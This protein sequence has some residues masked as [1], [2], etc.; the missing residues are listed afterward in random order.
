M[1]ARVLDMGTDVRTRL[2]RV[3]LGDEPAEAVLTG[4]RVV[5]VFTREIVR[6]DVV[7]A[8]G[9][10]AAVGDSGEQ[11]I[12]P[13]TE[14]ID[15]GGR[16]AAPGLID[17]HMHLESSNIT[18][19]ELARA[20]VPRG[21]LSVCEDPHEIANVL[22][23][24]GVDLLTAEAAR[25]PLN[26][27]LRVPGRVPAM[28]ADRETSGH[29]MDTAET[30]AMLDRPEAVC[31]GG[32]INPAL[33][34]GADRAQLEKI[35]ATVERDK[36]VGGQLPGFS[37]A[38]LDATLA[39]G[40]E[41]THVAE[42]PAEVVEQLRKGARVLLTPRIDRLPAEEWPEIVAATERLGLDTRRLVLC[43]DDIHPNILMSE[44][45]LDQRVRLAVEA[46][47]DPL[48]AVQMATLNA[49]ELM[50][51]DRHLGS[52]APGRFADLVL[53]ES[54]DE[55]APSTVL[56]RGEVVAADGTLVQTPPPADYPA[57]STGTLH[58]AVPSPADLALRVEAPDGPVTANAVAFGAPK[59]MHRVQLRARDGVVGPDSAADAA[60]IAVLER[61]HRTG[62]IGKGFVTGLGIRGGAV[63]STVNHDSHNVV[64]IGDSHA[65]MAAAAGAVI[66]AQG[67]YAVAVGTEVAAV[68]P[69]PIAGLLSPEPLEAVGERLA[70]VERVLIEELGC[71]IG[72]RPVYALNFL[73]LPNI[74]DVGFTDRGIIETATME[75][76]GPLAPAS[77]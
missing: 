45:H 13:D 34:L 23:V 72:Y 76:V 67:G 42:S 38:V 21:V 43:T 65:S 17:P 49:A 61:H 75:I 25:L 66:E 32:D 63:A 77:L 15:A 31:I 59:T 51:I 2:I 18:V 54:L 24:A 47:F 56:Y 11:L 36:T 6:A 70:A 22:G 1:T 19:T 74:P 40:V 4:A 9:R 26:L 12:G 14:I 53:L 52:V 30:L 60:A 16:F 27:L 46:G 48:T 28:P 69:L 62:N 39:A 7:M 50:R 10:I 71:S 57:W 73:C 44:G 37:G 8:A 3:A 5:N 55:F 64:V 58:V 68:V 33:L 29:A 20:I 35:E 41:D